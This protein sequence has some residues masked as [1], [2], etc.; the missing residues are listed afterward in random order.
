MPL[1]FPSLCNPFYMNAFKY[2]FLCWGVTMFSKQSDSWSSHFPFILFL[3]KNVIILIA[4]S[5]STELLWDAYRGAIGNQENSILRLILLL[6]LVWGRMLHVDPIILSTLGLG[7]F[8]FL[9][10]LNSGQCKHLVIDNISFLGFFLILFLD[11][12]FDATRC[13]TESSY[14]TL[15]APA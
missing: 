1:Y 7:F 2:S 13:Q 5:Y 15:G 6:K 4:A 11:L 14:S 9:V 8:G 10:C 3:C 12:F